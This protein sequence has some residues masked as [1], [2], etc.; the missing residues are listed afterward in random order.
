MKKIYAIIAAAMLITVPALS[1]PVQTTSAVHEPL[2]MGVLT[3]STSKTDD[4]FKIYLLFSLN[5]T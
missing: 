2:K 3:M 1:A 4:T 5:I